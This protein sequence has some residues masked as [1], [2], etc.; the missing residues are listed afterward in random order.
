MSIFDDDEDERRSRSLADALTTSMFRDVFPFMP[1]WSDQPGNAD[2]IT[3]AIADDMV[4]SS[5]HWLSLG[6]GTDM[7]IAE[8]QDLY[9]EMVR[10]KK[11]SGF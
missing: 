4:G 3:Q 1:A 10:R 11:I 8:A 7:T 2:L 6:Y 9:A 5:P